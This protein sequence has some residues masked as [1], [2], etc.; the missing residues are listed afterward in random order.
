MGKTTIVRKLAQDLEVGILAKDDLKE[1]LLES[2]NI[3][4]R[5]ESR[6]LGSAVARSL[7]IIADSMIEAGKSFIIESAFNKEFAD[8]DFGHLRSKHGV[9]MLQIFCHTNEQTRHE[10]FVSRITS[11]ERH[12]KHYDT[13]E[14]FLT[15]RR[16]QSPLNIEPLIRVDTT[17][18][19]QQDYLNLLSQVRAAL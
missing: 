14:D 1:L 3:Q 6:H 13:E 17:K 4:N 15:N 19:E 8:Q 12:P 11:G 7:Y 2:L 10:R 5:E 18:F 9:H 16:E